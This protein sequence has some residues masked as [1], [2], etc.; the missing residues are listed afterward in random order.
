MKFFANI[1]FLTL[2][3]AF[4]ANEA[5]TPSKEDRR[6]QLRNTGHRALQG[7]DGGDAGGGSDAGGEVPDEIPEVCFSHLNTVEVHGKGTI[8]IADI[9]IGDLV[10]SGED[11]SAVVGFGKRNE[12]VIGQYLQLSAEGIV[13]PLELSKDHM[14]YVGGK[15]VAASSVQVGDKLG[16]LE[17]TE[18]KEVLRRGAYA[19]ITENG[20]IN[21]N[22]VK[23]SCYVKFLD[24]SFFDQQAAFHAMMT[25]FRMGF[26]PNWSN[27]GTRAEWLV[28]LCPKLTSVKHTYSPFIQYLISFVGLPIYALALACI[29][30]A[31]SGILVNAGIVGFV[32]YKTYKNSASKVKGL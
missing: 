32:A 2:A 8:K 17:V 3:C 4:A 14:L 27:D 13:S 18:I 15:A 24:Y 30:F 1:L 10:R 22:G 6:N 5:E 28:N 9:E 19:P 12:E 31:N 7:G 11:F 16:D 23:A 21:V 25:P 26:V 20:N 29:L